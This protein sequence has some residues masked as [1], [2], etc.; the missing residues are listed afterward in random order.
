M[1]QLCI[2]VEQQILR[3]ESSQ[4]K[5]SYSVP[6]DKGEFQTYEDKIS[7]KN[8]PCEVEL[9]MIQ[10]NPNNQCSPLS[11]SQREKVFHTRKFFVVVLDWL[12]S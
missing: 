12:K 6:Y 10:R 1:I 5:S 3:K 9:L 11:N 8:Y 4:K 7:E 2:K